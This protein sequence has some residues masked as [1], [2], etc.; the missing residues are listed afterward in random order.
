[1]TT[2]PDF[3][4]LN[5]DLHQRISVIRS[6]SSVLA[7]SFP[8]ERR[9]FLPLVQTTKHFQ[10]A[11]SY[12]QAASLIGTSQAKLREI[13]KHGLHPAPAKTYDLSTYEPKRSYFS[14]DDLYVLRNICYDL[15]PKNKYGIPYQ[16]KLSSEEELRH[17][18]RLTDTRDYIKVDD[19][20]MVRIFRA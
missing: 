1:M 16:D 9:R 3:F 11:F 15:L 10:K 8:E 6:D 5:G 12:G 13:V 18:M 4:F 2:I 17:K 7:F 19:D 14:E 20:G